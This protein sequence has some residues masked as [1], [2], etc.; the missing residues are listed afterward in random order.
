VECTTSPTTIA[1]TGA[2]FIDLASLLRR[3]RTLA[4]TRCP[5][6]LRYDLPSLLLLLVLAKLAGEDRSSGIADWVK[7][8][9]TPLREALHL[10]WWTM[11]HHNTYR[12]IL[13]EVVS[14]EELSQ[15]VGE[16]L[17]SLPGTGQSVLIVIDGKTIRARLA[18][19]IRGG[20]TC[21]PP[22]CQKKALC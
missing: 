10:P 5:R 1:G 17:E 19:H 12:R 8:R 16:H 4:D 21:S 22:I 18:R 20:S 3:L 15:V 11:P 13:G 9:G 2:T 7:A 14:P 6:G